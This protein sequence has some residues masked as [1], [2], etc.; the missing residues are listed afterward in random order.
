MTVLT[1]C[2][3]I[4]A[5]PLVGRWL[6]SVSVSVSAPTAKALVRLTAPGPTVSILRRPRS[7]AVVFDARAIDIDLIADHLDEHRAVPPF[8]D[9]PER[10][11]RG[12]W[13]G[14]L[15]CGR[16][17][18]QHLREMWGIHFNLDSGWRNPAR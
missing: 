5:H 15:G 14:R 16:G 4:S 8:P 18:Q 10:P 1:S 17:L 3:S 2:V 11:V 6:K 7:L 9:I 12:E 13:K